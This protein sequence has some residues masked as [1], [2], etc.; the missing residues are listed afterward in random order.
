MH[1]AEACLC[2]KDWPASFTAHIDSIVDRDMLRSQLLLTH[3]RVKD[4]C[5]CATC[6]WQAKGIRS[7]HGL[8]TCKSACESS[9]LHSFLKRTP[10]LSG[11]EIESPPEN[12]LLLMAASSSPVEAAPL[13]EEAKEMFGLQEAGK[14]AFVMEGREKKRKE[15]TQSD[16]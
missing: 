12:F 13:H 14:R 8:S 6:S 9:V 11:F 4:A 16:Q 3:T 10:F 1:A 5:S 7:A 15:W 2:L